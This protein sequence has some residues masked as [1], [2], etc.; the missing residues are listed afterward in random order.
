MH[1]SRWASKGIF[2]VV[3]AMATTAGAATFDSDVPADVR[4]QMEEDLVF[5]TGLT[6]GDGTPMHQQ[7]FGAVDGKQYEAFFND[8]VKEIGIQ[9]C[10]NPNAVACVSPFM[11]PSKMWITENYIK[12]SHPQIARLQV[13]YHE[14]RHTEVKN[15]NWSH[16]RCPRPF[17]DENGKDHKSI[18]TGAPL[19]GEPACDKTPFGSYGSSVILLK[20]V[21]RSCTNCT[22]KV[23]T[24]AGIYG[25]NQFIRIIDKKARADMKK[26]LYS[27]KKKRK[28]KGEPAPFVSSDRF[29]QL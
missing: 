4:K 1:G 21:E 26:D 20:N 17:R 10:G 18:W 19:A 6:G 29:A 22:D 28:K 15:G 2:G 3:L 16:A 14:A 13:V 9:D 23:K 5:M 8:R 11:D 12:F 27:S 24:D 25:D 7:V